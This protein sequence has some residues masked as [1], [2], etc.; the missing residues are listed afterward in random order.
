MNIPTF[1][2]VKKILNTL[3]IGYYVGKKVDVN[4]TL[5]KASYYSRMDDVICISYVTLNNV[6]HK[7]KDK[8]TN[9]NVERLIR[10]LLYHEV[11]HTFLT[12]KKLTIDYVMNVFEDERIE[13]I[14]K[15]KYLNVDFYE[16]LKLINDWDGY[17]IPK[18]TSADDAWYI[19]IRYHIGKKELLE[20]ANTIL[21]NYLNLHGNSGH[22][23]TDRYRMDVLNLY[24][25]LRR[26]YLENEHVYCKNNENDD[27]FKSNDE[28]GDSSSKL[29]K[30][31][32]NKTL[33]DAVKKIDIKDVF[34]RVT[35]FDE[36]IKSKLDEIITN[37]KKINLSNSTAINSYSGVFNPIST[38]RNDY[39]WFV[40]QNRQGH[41]K[42][43]SKIKLNLFIDCS[44][45]F[46]GNQD[47][48]NKILYAL[49][50]I[51][52]TNSNF[53]FD[54]IAMHNYFKKLPKS[55]RQIV[56]DGGNNIPPSA[57]E[58]IKSA[59]DFDAIN[60]NIVLFDGDALTDNFES[61]KADGEEF[62]YFNLLKN[63]V[64]ILDTSNERYAEKYCKK[65]ERIYCV[66]YVNEL[67]QNV[68]KALQFLFR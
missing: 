36:N 31:Y 48:V 41:V 37:S 33:E 67:F 49:S 61:A 7:I 66:D 30:N 34:K 3:P 23:D 19:L 22:F 16:L 10:T 25:K 43:F 17:T 29:T 28:N 47:E 26:D 55:K 63:C 5:E 64:M 18:C 4:L 11:S 62:E 57:K 8:L 44:G 14:C 2:E 39:K 54:V 24:N 32:S 45:S 58:V 50:K 65:H 59:I 46:Y 6:M 21:M 35:F 52:K 38:I 53:T 51:E 13:M 40:Q 20:D 15:S 56:C 27:K 9:E 68:C 60:Y 42:Q 1:F 12:P